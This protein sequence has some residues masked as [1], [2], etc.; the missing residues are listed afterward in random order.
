MRSEIWNPDHKTR[1]SKDKN[2][3]SKRPSDTGR[4]STIY[5]FVFNNNNNNNN[6]NNGDIRLQNLRQSKKAV[7][8]Y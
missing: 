3:Y 5:V 6:N 2:K 4:I 1:S 8:C 7:E